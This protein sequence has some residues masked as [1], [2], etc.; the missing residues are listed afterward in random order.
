MPPPT[1][2]TDL[3]RLLVALDYDGTVT[4]REYNVLA[5]QKLTGDAWRVFDD[6]AWRGEISHAECLDGEVG[7][8]SAS[9]QELIAATANDARPAPGFAQFLEALVA[10]GARVAVVSAGFREAIEQLWRREKLPSVEIFASEIVPRDGVAGP[11]WKV[12]FDQRLGDCP[13]CGPRACKT[14]VLRRLRKPGDTVAAF[15]D[16]LSDLCLAREA[17]IVF[18]RGMLAELCEREGIAYHRLSDYRRA[19]AELTDRMTPQTATP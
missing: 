12:V 6:A 10:G 14:G 15:G 9:K 17:D 3:S 7:L 13:T 4:D 16:G 5:F 11:P 1:A 8:V 2:P 18:A 19:L